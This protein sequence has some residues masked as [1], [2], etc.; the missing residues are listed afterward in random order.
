MRNNIPMEK[1]CPKCGVGK[2]FSS[3]ASRSDGLNRV[4][5]ACQAD[6]G[7]A[8][9]TPEY[10]RD[11]RERVK[12]E[13]LKHYG[14][15]CAGCGEQ[16]LVVLTIDHIQGGGNVHRKETGT[17]GGYHFYRWLKKNGYPEGYRVLCMNCQFRAFKGV[18]HA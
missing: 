12:D 18:L 5:K 16:D 2:E 4:C 8:W 9:T 6:H 7:K 15:Q 11:Y 17:K 1:V 14:G 3:D 13:V 10:F